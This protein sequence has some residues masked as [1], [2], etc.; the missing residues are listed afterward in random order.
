MAKRTTARKPIIEVYADRQKRWRYR[1][2]AAN[3]E[4]VLVPGQS[5]S[6]RMNAR[7]AARRENPK[8]AIVSV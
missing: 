5:Y 2:K 1:R 4:I 7:R 8:L 3:G 6:T